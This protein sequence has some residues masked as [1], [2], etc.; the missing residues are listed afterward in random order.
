MVPLQ[1]LAYLLPLL[2]YPVFTQIPPIEGTKNCVSGTP[3]PSGISTHTLGTPIKAHHNLLPTPDDRAFAIRSRLYNIDCR[4]YLPSKP[5][6]VNGDLLRVMSEQMH[7]H[8][9]FTVHEPHQLPSGTERLV[10]A[11]AVTQSFDKRSSLLENYG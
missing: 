6:G 1:P 8:M 10:L 3:I 9:T 5:L 2:H 4:L 7:P 11:A